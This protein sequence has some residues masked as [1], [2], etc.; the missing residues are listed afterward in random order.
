MGDFDRT[1]IVQVEQVL[2]HPSFL[3]SPLLASVA[4]FD[5][6]GFKGPAG[7]LIGF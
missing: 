2:P 5:T 6:G 7:K 1:V 4:A 3:P